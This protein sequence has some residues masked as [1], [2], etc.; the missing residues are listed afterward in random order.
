M[1]PSSPDVPAPGLKLR[2]F[3]REDATIVQCSGRLTAEVSSL[4]KDEVKGLIPRAKII[5]LDLTDL[6]Y[7]DS[8]G[9]GTVVGLYVSA[10]KANSELR[11]INFNQRVRELLGI[12]HLLSAFEACGKYLIKMP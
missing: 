1:P 4:L 7:M 11:L 6:S 12:T 3:V 8:S 10:K 9:L 2:T 5:V